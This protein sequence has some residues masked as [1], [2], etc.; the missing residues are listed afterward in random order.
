MADLKIV[1]S[2]DPARSPGTSLSAALQLQRVA[3]ALGK[4]K[5]ARGFVVRGRT[6]DQAEANYQQKLKEMEAQH[7]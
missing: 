7:D 2:R 1:G 4:W 5:P 3:R 6:W